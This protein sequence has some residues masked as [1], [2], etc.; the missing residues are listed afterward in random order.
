MN[1]NKLLLESLKYMVENRFPLNEYA[2]EQMQ[3]KWDKDA[4]L[5]T[6]LYQLFVS[7]R[8]LLPLIDDI[9][10]V[11]YDYIVSREMTQMKTFYGAILFTAELFDTTQTYVKCKVE[12]CQRLYWQKTS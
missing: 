3:Q 1:T 11:T 4:R 10:A 2:V 8:H 5:I 9:E 6:E 7:N 12:Q